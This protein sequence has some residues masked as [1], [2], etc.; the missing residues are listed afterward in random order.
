MK[1]TMRKMAVCGAV[2]SLGGLSA[3]GAA[4]LDAA[5]GWL[6]AKGGEIVRKAERK[7]DDG[8]TVYAPQ[9]GDWY[10]AAWLRDYAM[11]QAGGLI[12]KE[13]QN[14]VAELYLSAVTPEGDGFDC[15]KF[16]GSVMQRPG[17]NRISGKPVMDGYTYVTAV[18]YETWKQT[19]D[20]QWLKPE[21]LD[22]L[23]KML[24]RMPHRNGLPWINPEEPHERAPWGFNDSVQM[25]G[26]L[27][28]MS[29]LEIRARREL[30]TLLTAAGRPDAEIAA[31]RQRATE[32]VLLVNRTFWDDAFGLYRAA[33]VRCRQH[34]VWGSAYAVWLGVAPDDRA[35]RIARYFRD[36]YEGIVQRGQIRHMPAG[37]YWDKTCWDK[38]DHYQ[39][40]HFWGTPTGWFCWTL[41]RVAPSLVDKTVADLIADY[42][43]R[44]PNERVFGETTSCPE[45]LTSVATPLQ[46]LKRLQA[47]RKGL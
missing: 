9:A 30:A 3:F 28:F 20:A 45:Y 22:T 14:G 46:G 26:N 37:E 38:K 40:G 6:E 41:E 39:N 15:I 33:T 24:D 44:G 7:M 5:I 35:D 17:Y 19:G 32:L 27:F 11:T 1:R 13:H 29:L 47:A 4:D 21:V 43:A 8:R 34:D 36:H 10:K 31:Q 12:P 42:K 23:A 25:T 2:L 18:I 16:D